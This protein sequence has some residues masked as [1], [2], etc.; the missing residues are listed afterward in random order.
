M[1]S[2]HP[3]R[4]IQSTR[5]EQH[6][7]TSRVGCVGNL[8]R[9]GH[10][11]SGCSALAQSKY[12]ERHNA[13]LKVFFF[14][15][16]GELGL[17]DSVPPCYSPAA[18]KPIYESPKALTFWD[19]PVYAPHTIVKANRKDARFVDHKTKKVW[20]VKMSCPWIEHRQK[21]SEEKTAKYGPLQ[22]ELKKQYSG[23]D[24]EQPKNEEALWQ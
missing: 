9:L 24:I 18:P 15:I 4:C 20:A 11:L 7:A 5:Q 13:A 10:V 19:V 21:K 3:L 14:E 23:Y 6:R 12:P 8:L 16:A 17:I 22:F 1:S 2:S